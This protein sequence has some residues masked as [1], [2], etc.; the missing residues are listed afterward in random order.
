M[1][2]YPPAVPISANVSMLTHE[3]VQ[4]GVAVCAPCLAAAPGQGFW[5]GRGIVEGCLL[6]HWLLSIFLRE[7][8][9]RA[10][11][12]FL[13][14]RRRKESETLP[15]PW[16]HREEAGSRMPSVVPSHLRDVNLYWF[17]FSYF[18]NLHPKGTPSG[19]ILFQFDKC[20]LMIPSFWIGHFFFVAKYKTDFC[21]P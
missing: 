5:S 18:V 9:P 14:T 2:A 10:H 19:F 6:S 13:L 17:Y 12:S 4:L 3:P 8:T 1:V 16:L 20:G 11:C 7:R 15:D 21:V